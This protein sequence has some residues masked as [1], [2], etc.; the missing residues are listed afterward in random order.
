MVAVIG[1]L[2]AHF[3][4]PGMSG[5]FLGVDVFFVISGF[6]IT[7]LII[8]EQGRSGNFSY[9]RFYLRRI[10]RLF[11]AALAVI[12]ISIVFFYPILG[13]KDLVSFLRSVPFAIFSLSNIN[14]WKEVGY[15]D[16]AAQFKPLLHTW[17]LAV[18]EQFYLFWPTALLL[19]LRLGRG[20]FAATLLLILISVLGAEWARPEHFSAAYYLLPFRAFELLVG[21][22]LAVLMAPASPGFRDIQRLAPP[23]M[24]ALAGAGM[25]M[26]LLSFILFDKSAPLPGLASL[27][28]CLGTAL[29]IAYGA[30]GPVGRF[31]TWRPVVWIGLISYSLYLVHWPV[32]V[33]LT[34][35]LPAEPSL[36]LSLAMIPL[37]ILLGAA[38]YYAVEQPFRQRRPTRRE[39]ARFLAAIGG[40][41]CLLILPSLAY[42]L[43]P[44]RPP[45]VVAQ[46][47]AA[48]GGPV[49]RSLVDFP[50]EDPVYLIE[51]WAA[52]GDQPRILVLGDSHGGHLRHG[53]QEVLAPYGFAVDMARIPGCPPLIDITI[54]RET[55]LGP[56][57]ACS[58][59]NGA[60]RA[61]IESPDYKAVILTSRWNLAVG[62]RDLPDHWLRHIDYVEIGD[63]APRL[64]MDQTRQLF[65][66]ALE[67]TLQALL[68]SGKAVVLLSQVPP[69]G[70]DLNQ[71]Q[72]LFPWAAD[73]IGPDARCA[74]LSRA[75]I[76]RRAAYADHQLQDF[77]AAADILYI[78]SNDL[79][80]D[81]AACLANAPGSG[82]L[83]YMDDNH[84]SKSGSAY[85]LDALVQQTGLI[86]FLS[87][88][89]QD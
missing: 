45:A 48:Y 30:A 21:A 7:R 42:K 47:R 83:L 71:C 33:Y 78:R 8:E 39:N 40:L 50:R 54:Q 34:Y 31:L 80:C 11:P 53:L 67:R 25:G 5:G 17:S 85:Y 1:V 56:D 43:A 35:R 32:W 51:R 15:F 61:L 62:E 66:R 65:D 3:H 10:R 26:I 24:A 44:E 4:I 73:Q 13:E 60:L 19:L 55:D 76:E 87:A 22:A 27:L 79:M 16:T 89:L 77:G 20:L 6:L 69:L 9:G 74:R 29:V 81:G 36:L 37:S 64:G 82:D 88:K 58:A 86:P 12:L 63:P 68:H 46:M 14:F 70:N 49:A 38:S 84:L 41:C 57:Q 2:L 28:P 18:E 75:D 59:A 52:A 72:A 23:R